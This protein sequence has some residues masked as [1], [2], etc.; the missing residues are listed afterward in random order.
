MSKSNIELSFEIV[1]DD[2]LDSTSES[3]QVVKGLVVDA[4]EHYKER[5]TKTELKMI[6]KLFHDFWRAEG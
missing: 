4:L 6:D 5:A 1:N 3:H 2:V